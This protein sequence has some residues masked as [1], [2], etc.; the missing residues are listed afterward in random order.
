MLASVRIDAGTGLADEMQA[1]REIGF[2]DR[3]VWNISNTVLGCM[4][5]DVCFGEKGAGDALT[6]HQFPAGFL[7]RK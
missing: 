5:R 7:W 1:L 3:Q 6:Q 4:L 2:S